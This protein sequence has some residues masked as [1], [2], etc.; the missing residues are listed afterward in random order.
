[1]NMATCKFVLQ[2]FFTLEKCEMYII[3]LHCV[4]FVMRAVTDKDEINDSY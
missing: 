2:F 4:T 1:M 3:K